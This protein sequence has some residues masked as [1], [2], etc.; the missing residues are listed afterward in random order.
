[1]RTQRKLEA[2]IVL[3]LEGGLSEE[4]GTF[5]S[6]SIVT[7]GKKKGWLMHPHTLDRLESLEFR[8]ECHITP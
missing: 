4:E 1:M 8:S 7:E 5:L 6:A 2:H 3:V